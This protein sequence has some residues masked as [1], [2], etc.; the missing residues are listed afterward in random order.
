MFVA[1]RPPSERANEEHQAILD[2][3][4]AGDPA[5]ADRAIRTHLDS[6]AQDLAAFLGG[7][8]HTPGDRED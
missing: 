3:C 6:A 1:A 4:V 8:G 5:T 2:A 7:D